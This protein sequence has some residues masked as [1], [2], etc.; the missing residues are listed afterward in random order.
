[1]SIADNSTIASLLSLLLFALHFIAKYD[2]KISMQLLT[3]KAF[4]GQVDYILVSFLQVKNTA[5]IS[6]MDGKIWGP[7]A[8]ALITVNPLGKL[9]SCTE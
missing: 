8:Q 5:F 3:D 6:E 4:I 2:C 1:M 7:Y 9:S